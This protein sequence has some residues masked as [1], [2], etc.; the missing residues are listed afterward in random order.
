V[1]DIAPFLVSRKMN[2][3][4]LFNC[5]F[6]MWRLTYLVV[7]LLVLNDPAMSQV[8]RRAP[9]ETTAVLAD[10]LSLDDL[11]GS[12]KDSLSVALSCALDIQVDSAARNELLAGIVAQHLEEGRL[13]DAHAVVLRVAVPRRHL[14]EADLVPFCV[15]AG[16]VETGRVL[17]ERAEAGLPQTGHVR[18]DALLGKLALA[19]MVLGDAAG[20]EKKLK[21]IRDADELAKAVGF[22]FASMKDKIPSQPIKLL[23]SWW[24]RGITKSSITHMNQASSVLQIARAWAGILKGK[25]EQQLMFDLC[26][27]AL[28]LS[29]QSGLSN[30][31]F[32]LRVVEVLLDNGWEETALEWVEPLRNRLK[33]IALAIE[34][35]ASA[36]ARL[37]Y[38]LKRL[39]DLE[40]GAYWLDWSSKEL[41][42]IPEL[43]VRVE[44]G[45]KL[46]AVHLKA[47]DEK[48]A[49][50]VWDNVLHAVNEHPNGEWRLQMAGLMAVSAAGLGADKKAEWPK[51]LSALQ[52]IRKEDD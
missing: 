23:D 16:D 5:L 9:S 12:W 26:Q 31:E 7:V 39:G 52:E 35:Q 24:E 15:D 34:D 49:F 4:C 45:L 17:F 43:E 13:V 42:A 1:L 33:S 14:L 20:G 6:S 25:G 8:L 10:R 40:A 37:G 30:A 46:G 3:S 21:A 18:H 29:A 44:S 51:L 38:V 28:D 47:G 27:R 32:R 2:L 41:A 19:E 36:S 50:E 48:G 11:V 22:W